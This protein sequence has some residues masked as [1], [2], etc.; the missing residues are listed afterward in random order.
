MSDSDA[1]GIRFAPTATAEEFPA[2]EDPRPCAYCNPD[3][4]VAERERAAYDRA[5]ER[6]IPEFQIPDDVGLVHADYIL[7]FGHEDGAGVEV[8]VCDMCLDGIPVEHDGETARSELS[9]EYAGNG[10]IAE[11][12]VERTDGRTIHRREVVNDASE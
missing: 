11:K 10:K 12:T 2:D 1:T 7:R 6:N 5:A 3:D 9:H 4:R 8:P